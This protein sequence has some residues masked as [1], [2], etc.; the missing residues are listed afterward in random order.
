MSCS[1]I[2]IQGG[3]NFSHGCPVGAEVFVSD[4]E[5]L[6]AKAELGKPYELLR[7]VVMDNN[8]VITKECRALKIKCII[9]H[10]IYLEETRLILQPIEG[11]KKPDPDAS[12]PERLSS[13]GNLVWIVFF[14]VIFG[15]IGII[16][17]IVLYCRYLSWKREMNV[18]RRREAATFCGFCTDLVTHCALRKQISCTGCSET[19]ETSSAEVQSAP[20]PHGSGE[21][22]VEQDDPLGTVHVHS[23]VSGSDCKTPHTRSLDRNSSNGG[24]CPTND[25]GI[26]ALDDN[27]AHYHRAMNR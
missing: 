16:G 7:E 20:E 6:I 24:I 14:S 23:I 13:G 5:I 4:N 26:I 1:D 25:A 15:I 2:K 22:D 3:F 19:G 18:T 17:I 10:G 12:S 9:P 8:S 21:N 11:I 27:R